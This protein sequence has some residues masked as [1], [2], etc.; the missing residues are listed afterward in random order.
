MAAEF[1]VLVGLQASG[2]SSF[3]AE[4]FSRTHVV[5][6]K[7]DFPARKREARQRRA[8][9]AAF[10]M[11][12]DVVLDNT[13]PSRDERSWA[14]ERARAAGYRSVGYYF[15]WRQDDAPRCALNGWSYWTLRKQGATVAAATAR[16][17]GL[18]RAEKEA[19]LAA[20]GISF[21]ETPLWQQ[22]GSGLYWNSYVKEGFDP[23]K[24]VATSALRRRL[25]WEEALPSGDAYR[26]FLR[27]F[28]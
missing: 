22:T 9:E 24:Q 27:A 25:A 15:R 5:V 10:G 18:T 8:L 23:V 20:Y 19:L 16:L 12:K 3:C 26:D 11:Q 17:E 6:S 4:R 2:K 14:L 1:V 13:N 28:L 7:D 21:A